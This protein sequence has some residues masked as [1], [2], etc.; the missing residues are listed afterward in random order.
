MAR[1]KTA[2]SPA[3]PMTPAYVG[4]EIR[5]IPVAK[6]II[7]PSAMIL[8]SYIDVARAKLFELR[9]GNRTH[10]PKVFPRP[11]GRYAVIHFE[12]A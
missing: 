8:P 9:Y 11:D 12:V 3:E 1:K 7:D 6:L 5:Q 10:I 2:E 4:N